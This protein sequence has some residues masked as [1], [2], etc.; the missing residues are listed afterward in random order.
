MIYWK[1]APVITKL[2]LEYM[3]LVRALPCLCCSIRGITRR[4][5]AHHIKCGNKRMGHRF[6]LALCKGHHKGEFEAGEEYGYR[7]SVHGN[8]RLF[9]Q[10]Y[11]TEHS[12]WERQQKLLG[13]PTTG[14]PESKILPRRIA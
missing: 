14:W 5:T 6:V 9:T 4:S 13:L 1:K 3:E 8:H 12:L 7:L 10:T 11:G 2:E